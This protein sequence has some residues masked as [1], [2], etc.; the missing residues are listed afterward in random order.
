M[1]Q[2]FVYFFISNQCININT[3]REWANV[4]IRFVFCLFIFEVIYLILTNF[5]AYL[6]SRNRQICISRS[7]NIAISE[8]KWLKGFKILLKYC[9][10]FRV[11]LPLMSRIKRRYCF[12]GYFIYDWVIC[13]F[14]IISYLAKLCVFWWTFISE[15]TLWCLSWGA[16]ISFAVIPGHVSFFATSRKPRKLILLKI[17]E[18]NV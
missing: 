16:C 14:H 7:F 10:Y 15:D 5:C 13:H 8:E 12:F 11:F 1:H 2:C 6:I 9:L 3:E 18:N 4:H 17:S